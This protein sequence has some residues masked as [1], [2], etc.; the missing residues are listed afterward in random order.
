MGK[1]LRFTIILVMAT[2]SLV[3]WAQNRTVSG[4][5][6]DKANGSPIPGVNVT[7]TLNGS[8][9]GTTT[10]DSG[11][12]TLSVP[13]GV[14]TLRFSSVG[15]ISQ[16]LAVSSNM[17]VQLAEEVNELKEVVIAV[18]SRAVQRTYTDTPL[19]VDNLTAKEIT[20]SG[21]VTFDKALQYRVPSFNSNN[22]P[23]QD[24]TSL[25]DPYELRNLGPSR[26][27]I[28]INGKRKNMSSLV[29][30]QNTVGKGETGADLAAIPTGAIKRVEIL[31]DGASA[32]YGSDAM[33]GVM[34]IIL[35]DRVE[36]TE[37]TLQ[38]G[39]YTKGDGLMFGTNINTGSSFD[40]GGFVNYN[41]AFKQQNRT[42]RS[43]DLDPKAE[44]NTLTGKTPQD[45]I[46]VYNFLSKYPDGKNINGIPEIT[47][48]NFGVNAGINVG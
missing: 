11:N 41:L 33:A 43:G 44:I 5:V 12:F 32:Q 21:Q 2:M 38:S 7:F 29:Y 18:G 19:P 36:Y 14:S 4:K 46:D 40:N 24:A 3:A 31:R 35:K 34:N 28:L 10:D 13:N 16:D 23:V 39:I 45:S 30:V 20:A 17:N 8:K 9:G 47:S 27:L 25:L 37:A 1:F 15:Y 22:L 26:T 6:S 42:N 48:A